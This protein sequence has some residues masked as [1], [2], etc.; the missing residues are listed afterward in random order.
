MVITFIIGFFI[1]G[2]L[3]LKVAS[4]VLGYLQRNKYITIKFHQK[5]ID[6]Y[7]KLRYP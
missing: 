5:Y 1:G 4:L 7:R 3:T 6:E 2:F